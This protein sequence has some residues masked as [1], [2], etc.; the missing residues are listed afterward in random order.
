[1]ASSN[2]ADYCSPL[3]RPS[4][5]QSCLTVN[6]LHLSIEALQWKLHRNGGYIPEKVMAVD[7]ATHRFLGTARSSKWFVY[8]VVNLAVFTDAYLYG[9]IIP[10]LPFAL[11][12][13]VNLPEDGVQEWIGILLGAYGAG[14]IVGA[15][16]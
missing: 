3:D 12:E 2:R 13:R 15:R 9:L 8:I 4:S 1:M 5:S 16:M 7:Y 14:L 10:V 11:V 6:F